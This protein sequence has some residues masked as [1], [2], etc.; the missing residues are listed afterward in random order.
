[1]MTLFALYTTFPHTKK[2]S[3]ILS[4]LVC[5]CQRLLGLFR[6][7]TS[8]PN[9]EEQKWDSEPM[10]HC[11]HRAPSRLPV[12]CPTQKMASVGEEGGGGPLA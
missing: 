6:F 7:P 9:R 3:T 1:M 8:E 10:S 11:T 5:F 4:R 12:R 2:N